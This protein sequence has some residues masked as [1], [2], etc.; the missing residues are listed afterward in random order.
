M[1]RQPN[2]NLFF[3]KSLTKHL[4]TGAGGSGSGSEA[5]RASTP[6]ISEDEGKGKPTPPTQLEQ[7]QPSSPPPSRVPLE[8]PRGVAESELAADQRAAEKKAEIFSQALNDSVDSVESSSEKSSTGTPDRHRTT[9]RS[10]KKRDTRS[11]S[12]GRGGYRKERSRG[13]Y[14]YRSPVR[15][16]PPSHMMSPSHHRMGYPPPVPPGAFYHDRSQSPLHQDQ[17][18]PPHR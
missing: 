16:H 17:Y 4:G 9:K 14:S 7:E 6:T 5:S 1:P 2:N 10:T 12:G 15:G 13:G 11:Y 3:K 8:P 18:Y